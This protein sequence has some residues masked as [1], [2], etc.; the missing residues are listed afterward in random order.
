[1]SDDVFKPIK[2]NLDRIN[3]DVNTKK[4]Q[5]LLHKH[6]QDNLLQRLNRE[7]RNIDNEL[8]Y[9]FLQKKYMSQ[10]R[11]ENITLNHRQ[12]TRTTNS[13]EHK[14]RNRQPTDLEQLT[15]A[16]IK[17]AGFLVSGSYE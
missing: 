10:D 15:G 17:I 5:G 8:G 7:K 3:V 1:M 14:I 4:Y 16:V 9:T 12:L 2:I 13:I 6:S 11:L